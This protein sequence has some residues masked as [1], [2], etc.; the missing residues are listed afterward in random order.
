ME[1]FL[2]ISAFDKEEFGDKDYE[3]LLMKNTINT[4]DN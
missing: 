1:R 2:S 4:K 3:I